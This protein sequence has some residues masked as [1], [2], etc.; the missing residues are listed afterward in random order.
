[1]TQEQ[2]IGQ[3]NE[4]GKTRRPFF[5]MIDFEMKS[6]IAWRLD[7]I[8]SNQIKINFPNF[9]NHTILPVT[10]NA[11]VVNSRPPVFED[12]QVKFNKVFKHLAYGD[13]FLTNLTIKTPI[14]VNR[15]LTQLY[16][17]ASAPYKLLYKNDFLVYSP[18]SFVK[19]ADGK[20][21]TYPM[22][23]TIDASL[24]NAEELILNDKKEFAEH[25][26]I[27]DLLRNDLS[28]VAEKIRVKRF[29]YVDRIKTQDRTLLQV[30]SEIEGD[31]PGNYFDQ[32]G[33]LLW[34]LLPAGSVS[35]A[36]K[37]KTL[38]IISGAEGEARGYYTGVMGCFDGENLDSAVMIRYIEL[39]GNQLYYRSGGGITTQSNCI[40]EYQEA[41]TK[42]Y[43]PV[44]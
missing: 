43:V 23:G 33:T 13:S 36:P 30:S 32:L 40:S 44:I 4:W 16:A 19:I 37:N 22:K 1:M 7:H 42:I 17:I 31:L 25:V 35:G 2:F 6:P 39:Q 21:Y 3:L 24:P 38:E 20:I 28:I 41:L 5:F 26:T 29:R 18:E 34:K 10:K 15:T 27:V 12:Y 11:L 8:D 9:T 14:E